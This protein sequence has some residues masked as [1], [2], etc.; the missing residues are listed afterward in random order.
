MHKSCVDSCLKRHAEN[1]QRKRLAEREADDWTDAEEDC[2]AKLRRQDAPKRPAASPP[3]PDTV[4]PVTQRPSTWPQALARPSPQSSTSGAASSPPALG[5]R[6]DEP[7][8]GRLERDGRFVQGGASLAASADPLAASTRPASPG[9]AA[10]PGQLHQGLAGDAR[11]STDAESPL[12]S[13]PDDVWA[14]MAPGPTQPGHAHIIPSV[15]LDLGAGTAPVAAP[16]ALSDDGQ[17]RAGPALVLDSDVAKD[18]PWDWL[19][20]GTGV[21]LAGSGTGGRGWTDPPHHAFLPALV[22]EVGTLPATGEHG[23]TNPA[24]HVRHPPLP[25]FPPTTP[26]PLPV[27]PA[28]YALAVRRLSYSPDPYTLAAVVARS[29]RGG[30]GAAVAVALAHA[31]TSGGAPRAAAA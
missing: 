2:W 6:L 31:A 27:G 9:T 1:R 17:Q 22:R 14:E 19:E 4:Q 29:P 21:P 7:E 23:L 25:A 15:A 18:W 26:P 10:M 11:V 5:Q 28:W 13:S 20:A 30:S 3:R 12:L 16:V 24:H 8:D